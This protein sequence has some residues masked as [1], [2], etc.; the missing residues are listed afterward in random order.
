MTL[1][2]LPAGLQLSIMQCLSDGRDLVSLGQ[3][4]PELGALTEDRLLWKKLCQYHFTDRQVCWLQFSQKPR[5]SG[6]PSLHGSRPNVR[7]LPP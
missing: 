3:V 7:L 2:D 6:V 1:I 4:C 5:Y